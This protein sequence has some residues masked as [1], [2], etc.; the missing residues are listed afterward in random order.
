[1][2]HK[3]A[4]SGESSPCTSRPVRSAT[5]RHEMHSAVYYAVFVKHQCRHAGA[6][7]CISASMRRSRGWPRV[8]VHVRVAPRRCTSARVS[9][10]VCVRVVHARN[11][12]DSAQ[13][14]NA[15]FGLRASVARMRGV[16]LMFSRTTALVSNRL[17]CVHVR[18]YLKVP[19]SSSNLLTSN[20]SCC[21]NGNDTVQTGNNS[22]R[23]NPNNTVITGKNGYYNNLAALVNNN[24]Y[25]RSDSAMLRRE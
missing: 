24:T 17:A 15:L 14:Y 23:N 22:Y 20:I 9:A 21:N 6:H 25:N 4:T 13:S 7:M 10:W 19:R 3:M 11:C 16:S 1:M 12:I 5:A 18:A 8:W 2:N